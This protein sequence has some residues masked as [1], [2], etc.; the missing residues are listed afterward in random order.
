V[1]LISITNTRLDV[2]MSDAVQRTLGEKV[3]DLKFWKHLD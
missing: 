1:Y 2:G 3:T